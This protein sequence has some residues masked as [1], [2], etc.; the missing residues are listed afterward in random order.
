MSWAGR[1]GNE[2]VKA[3]N[4]EVNITDNQ[5]NGCLASLRRDLGCLV[6]REMPA[7]V[8]AAAPFRSLSCFIFV[9]SSGFPFATRLTGGSGHSRNSY[10]L[11]FGGEVSGSIRSGVMI[12]LYH[13]RVSFF[14]SD[15]DPE[16]NSDILRRVAVLLSFLGNR[17]RSCHSRTCCLF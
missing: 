2:N 8:F 14:I 12:P 3:A 13:S 16:K 4:S 15:Y 6:P 17:S 10:V 1:F 9:C 11:V 5:P 7:L